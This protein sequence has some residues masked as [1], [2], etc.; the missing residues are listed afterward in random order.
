M[1][2]WGYGEGSV[3]SALNFARGLWGGDQSAQIAGFS[4]YPQNQS[5]AI[6]ALRP[7]HV[8]SHDDRVFLYAEYLSPGVYRYEYFL[9]ALVPGTFQHMPA[10][11]RELYFPEIFGRT[12]GDTVT[13]IEAD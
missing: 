13:V 12:S 7:T 9:R 10:T 2:W 1:P 5:R 8:E 4:G 6:E 3:S 11:A